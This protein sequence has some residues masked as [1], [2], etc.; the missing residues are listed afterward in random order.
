M[1]PPPDFSPARCAPNGGLDPIADVNDEEQFFACV[2]GYCRLVLELIR[3]QGNDDLYKPQIFLAML[4][5]SVEEYMCFYFRLVGFIVLIMQHDHPN[6]AALDVH[7][8]EWTQLRDGIVRAMIEQE[9][10]TKLHLDTMAKD[11]QVQYS[12]AS[13]TWVNR[14]I[15]YMLFDS[16]RTVAAYLS[17]IANLTWAHPMQIATMAPRIGK[18]RPR[19][20]RLTDRCNTNK[21]SAC[22][23]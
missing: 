12:R 4:N 21:G 17:A 3:G 19:S 11:G 8:N 20:Q 23:Q 6:I 1:S 7:G 15:V 16:K 2:D 14:T 10:G 22:P 9:F 5:C 13:A 18:V